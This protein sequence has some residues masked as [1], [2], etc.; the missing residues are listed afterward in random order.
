[1]FTK[2]L[3]LKEE[4]NQYVTGNGAK[5]RKQKMNLSLIVVGILVL[6]NCTK[7]V[8]Y[9]IVPETQKEQN[10]SKSLFDTKAEYLMA[11]SQQQSS[12]S[13][14][15]AFPFLAGDNKRVKLEVGKD[16]LRI[17]ET[18]KDERF[19][20]NE[21]NTKLVL[22]IPI[23]HLQYRCAK[24]KYGKCTN[25]EEEASDIPWTN[26]D[27]VKIKFESA[28]SGQLDL[29]PIMSSQT[30]GE[31]CYEEVSSQLI[32]SEVEKDAINFQVKRTFK[33]K[34]DCV[35]GEGAS[36]MAE[37]ISDATISAVYHY[38]LVKTDSILSK[39]YKVI[40]YPQS[41][42]DEQS[43]G[44]FSTSRTQLAAD[45]NNTD[46]SVIQIMNRWNP[47]RKEI[48]YYLSDEFAKPENKLVKKLTY[49]TV[50][51]INKGLETA[52]VNF[53]INLQEPAGKVPGDI[54][55]SMIVL[56]EDPVAASVIG[57][58]PQTEDPKTGEIVSA[59]TVMFLG[60]IKKYIKYTYDDIIRE[61]KNALL[62]ATKLQK[63][64]PLSQLTLSADLVA[65][66]EAKKKSGFTY[67]LEKMNQK[68][69][70]KI[71][72]TEKAKV[73]KSNPIL[74][75]AV[76]RS[77]I[78]KTLK[79]YTVNRNDEF[80][81]QNLKSKINYLQFAKNCA[82]SPNKDSMIGSISKKLADQF[83]VDSKP[84]SELS[85]SEQESAIAIILPEIW[86]ATLIH[87]MGHNLG[88]R[89]NFQGSED[90]TNFY[91]DDELAAQGVTDRTVVSSSV[92]EYIDDLKALTVLGKYDIAAL[93][94][95]YLR[96][97][98]L[99][100][101]T[102]VDVPTTLQN[103]KGEIKNYGFCTDDHLGQNAGCKQFDLGTSYTEI[104]QNLIQSYELGYSKR[105]LRDGRADM[106]L[107]KDLTYAS[108][109]NG[110]FRDIRI[111]MEVSERIKYRYNLADSA[112]EW[113]SI[114]FLKDLKTATLLGGQFLAG[115]ML[116]PDTTCAIALAA[117][118][119]QVVG[120]MN[121][122]KIN[123]DAVSCFNVEGLAADYI[124]VAQAG[125]SFNSKKDPESTNAFAD[126]IDVRG[127]WLDKI[128]AT[129]QLMTRQIGSFTMDKNTDSFLNT[130]ELRSGILDAVNGILTNNVVS[131]VPFTL[132]DGSKV[133]FEIG[134]DLN[135][136]QIIDQTIQPMIA[137]RMGINEH[138]TTK[139]QQVVALTLAK[140]A[141]DASGANSA[142]NIL[143]DIV[144]VHRLDEISDTKLGKNDQSL[145]IETTRYVATKTNQVA[146]DSITNFKLATTLEKLPLATLEDILKKK[147]AGQLAAPANS[148]P[149]EKAVWAL[150][151]ET[152]DA[153]LNEVIKSSKFYEDLLR[154]LPTT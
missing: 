113:E 6:T 87:E 56:V 103:L 5:M 45:N 118:P 124:T 131:K 15:D 78:E 114:P 139:L 115:V 64:V 151:K 125:K 17:V 145:M 23:E 100:D 121:L 73:E 52:G 101:A 68:V 134:Y 38:S 40:S 31:N 49:E 11:A 24:D 66:T 74:T 104:V 109:I 33:T 71:A 48:N 108:R 143:A 4:I 154:V 90:K 107:M 96:K 12:R 105:N 99:A 122:K 25:K 59:R 14:S 63:A 67:N 93:K 88:L 30:V 98:E 119:T 55:N 7:K 65:M 112:P 75:G 142:D 26:K 111:M 29:L 127:I 77:Q 27:T 79:N 138:S 58:G 50:A 37:V 84:W 70:A 35:T 28:K 21:T 95:G 140:N 1:M 130:T 141:V 54:R 13:A 36:S 153:F 3:N 42:K 120:I 32:K 18:E 61:K 152:I 2:N 16:S 136:S 47:D 85:D 22:E 123:P 135:E 128:L 9:E 44:F 10:V 110:I 19:A 72:Q 94:F 137:R 83:P 34:L 117:K 39:D 106:S 82:M 46:K 60:T 51:N 147:Q 53:R 132:A 126:Q 43:F 81:G 41:S 57:Y 91:S 150:S 148:K 20:S 149:E 129:K 86:V 116:V 89:H 102:V 97:V 8:D 62:E 144:S 92:M 133:E 80:A 146:F 76:Q 69:S